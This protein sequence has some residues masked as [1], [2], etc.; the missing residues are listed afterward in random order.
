MKLSRFE[1]EVDPV[2]L[3]R[4]LEYFKRNK[5]KKVLKK[6]DTHFEFEVEGTKNYI[7]V[8]NFMDERDTLQETTCSCPYDQGPYCKHQV[9]AFYYLL[10]NNMETE[11]GAV[12][13]N[14]RLSLSRLYKNEL[15]EI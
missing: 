5:L 12:Y 1:N 6:D 14:L 9:T 13:G 10:E 2:I 7:V 3:E 4:G 8:V 11:K 15:I